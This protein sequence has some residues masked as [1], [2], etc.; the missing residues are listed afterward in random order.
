MIATVTARVLDLRRPERVTL[1]MTTLARNSPV[2]LAIAIAAFPDRPLIAVALVVG[3]LIELPVLALTANRFQRQ[4]ARST[5]S[6]NGST[7][8]DGT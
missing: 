1:T 6:T 7:P 4:P 5:T 3:P 8:G 2:A